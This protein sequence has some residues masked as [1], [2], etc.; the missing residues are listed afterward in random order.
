MYVH[1]DAIRAIARYAVIGL[2]IA[3]TLVIAACGSS[4]SG[5]TGADA[6]WSHCES[7]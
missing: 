3:S 4:S 6:N 7:K 5:A 1:L 2:A